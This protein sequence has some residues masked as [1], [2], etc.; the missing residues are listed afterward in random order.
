M[1]SRLQQ[2]AYVLSIFLAMTALF[3]LQDGHVTRNLEHVTEFK[4][5]IK[6]QFAVAVVQTFGDQPAFDDVALVYDGV[7]NF[8]NQTAAAFVSLMQDRGADRDLAVIF[9]KTYLTFA[10]FVGKSSSKIAGMQTDATT[11]FDPG[12]FMTESPVYLNNELRI[13]NYGSEN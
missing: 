2:C 13:M 9:K 8:Y 7:A 3:V 11:K 5:E 1:Q 10:R 4:Q 12:T 6:N